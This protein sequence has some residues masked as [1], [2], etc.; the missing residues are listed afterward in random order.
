MS[1]SVCL[2]VSLS[3]SLSVPVYPTVYLLVSL[4]LS[5]CLFVWAGVCL[6]LGLYLSVCMFESVRF[7]MIMSFSLSGP[8]CVNGSERAYFSLFV[9]VFVRDFC[10]SFCACLS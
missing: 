1:D 6:F 2:M 9:Y 8:V 4:S 7:Y 10:L 3:F 5:R